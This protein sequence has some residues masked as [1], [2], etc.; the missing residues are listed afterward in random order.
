MGRNQPCSAT[1]RNASAYV[2]SRKHC[3]SAAPVS[4]STR[5][6]NYVEGTLV[7]MV[8]TLSQLVLSK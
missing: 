6:V 8:C 3:G 7:K 5:F 1:A 4:L 2:K